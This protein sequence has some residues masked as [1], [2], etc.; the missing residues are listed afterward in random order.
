MVLK[1]GP[2]DF[3]VHDRHGS[4]R[5]REDYHVALAAA[6]DTRNRI[7]NVAHDAG[8]TFNMR[9]RAYSYGSLGVDPKGEYRGLAR[10]AQTVPNNLS[11]G[12]CTDGISHSSGALYGVPTAA[13]SPYLREMWGFSACSTPASRGGTAPSSPVTTAPST[14]RSRIGGDDTR[15]GSCRADAAARLETTWP[16][17]VRGGFGFAHR[18]LPEAN[19]HHRKFGALRANVAGGGNC[20]VKGQYHF[21][22]GTGGHQNGSNSG[23]RNVKLYR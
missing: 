20:T 13:V 16:R 14:P 9:S 18:A 11:F 10:R 3:G 6:A 15:V 12:Q 19:E 8:G 7:L 21:Y 2:L 17:P 4:A 22:Y 23:T 5:T 1:N